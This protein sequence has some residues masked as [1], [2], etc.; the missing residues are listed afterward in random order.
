MS[1]S[2][3]IAML[4]I[5]CAGPATGQMAPPSAIEAYR[6][7]TTVSPP[8]RRDPKGDEIVICARRDADKYR[9][10]LITSARGNPKAESTS[11]ERERLQHITTPCDQRGPFLVGCGMVGVSVS[12]RVGG[13][14]GI[15]YR[16]LAP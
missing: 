16:T 13:G 6:T 4:A 2:L 9:V 3:A 5:G 7:L 1:R 8:C 10:P 14:D 15:Q 11:E 12:T